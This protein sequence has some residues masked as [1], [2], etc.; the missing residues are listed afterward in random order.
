[1]HSPC[2]PV[3]GS[4]LWLRHSCCWW[5]VGGTHFC[6]SDGHGRHPLLAS[7]CLFASNGGASVPCICLTFGISTGLDSGWGHPLPICQPWLTT[8]ELSML[9]GAGLQ[10]RVG[11]SQWGRWRAS[12]LALTSSWPAGLREDWECVIFLLFLLQRELLSPHPSSTLPKDR[13]SFERC[14]C[15]GLERE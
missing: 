8:T 9:G 6:L 2:S 14:L 7:E 12:E 11:L 13:E 15:V 3:P 1:M 4:L 5:A 10:G